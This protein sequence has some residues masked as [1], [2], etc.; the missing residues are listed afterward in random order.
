MSSENKKVDIGLR[1]GRLACV[2]R[3]CGYTDIAIE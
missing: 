1:N 3:S 2:A